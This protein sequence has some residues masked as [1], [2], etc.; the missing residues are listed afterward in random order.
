MKD[1]IGTVFSTAERIV[2]GALCDYSNA[3]VEMRPPW[4]PKTDGFAAWPS[5]QRIVA[6]TKLT[7]RGVQIALAKLEAGD[8]IRCIYRSKGGAPK[9]RGDRVLPAKTNCYL[10]TPNSL[11]RS[12]SSSLDTEPRSEIPTTP[13]SVRDNPEVTSPHNPEL[14]SPEVFNHHHQEE[15]AKERSN[16]Q[17]AKTSLFSNSDD[18]DDDQSTRKRVPITDDPEAEFAARLTE[19]SWLEG[20]IRD[21]HSIVQIVND[22]LKY[23][24]KLFLEFLNYEAPLTTPEKIKSAAAHYRSLVPKFYTARSERRR[25]EQK[26]LDRKLARRV[27]KPEPICP[28]SKCNGRGE[29]YDNAGM[30]VGICECE[31]GQNMPGTVREMF[32]TL[33]PAGVA[34]A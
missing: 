24:R 26:E 29:V 21:V 13:N 34:V 11:H 6:V 20:P 2:F 18:D 25:A 14:T 5:I 9:R 27:E 12:D 15:R 28:L 23:D 3:N 1:L 8:A 7:D 19:R 22:G 30:P 33:I 10:L 4:V 16:A 17:P 32:A 31:A